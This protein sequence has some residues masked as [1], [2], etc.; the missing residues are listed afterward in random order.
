MDVRAKLTVG[1]DG[2]HS[3][4]RERAGLSVRDFGAPIDVLWMRITRKNDDPFVPLGRFF[5][6]HILVMIFREEYWQCAY[7]IPKGG[8]DEI[9]S[10]R[11][12]CIPCQD[13]RESRHSWATASMNC[14]RGT[15][16]ACSR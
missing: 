9:K 12:G 10:A 6:G 8:Y 7:V 3:T 14:N 5:N 4:I 2:R 11:V 13:I 16:S 1:C 15:T